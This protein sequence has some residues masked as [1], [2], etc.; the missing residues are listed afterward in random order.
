MAKIVTEL[1]NYRARILGDELG[2][3]LTL[4]THTVL[5]DK[6]ILFCFLLVGLLS[7]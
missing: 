2:S 5:C 3:A 6:G 4:L 1:L 7:K